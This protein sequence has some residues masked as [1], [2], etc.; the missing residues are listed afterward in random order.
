MKTFLQF[1]VTMALYLVA[2]ILLRMIGASAV[3][4]KNTQVGPQEVWCGVPAKNAT[5]FNS[6]LHAS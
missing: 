3:L 6:F 2:P 4:V 1:W 5:P